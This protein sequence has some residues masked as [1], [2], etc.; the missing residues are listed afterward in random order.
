MEKV[1]MIAGGGTGGHIYPA[2]ALGQEIKRLLPQGRIIYIGSKR[3]LEVKLMEQ[4]Q[5][6]FYGLNVAGLKGK[7]LKVINNLLKLPWSLGQAWRL[8]HQFRP[9]LVIGMGGYS[10]GPV[11]LAASWKKIPS[12]LLEQNARLGMTNKLLL[13]R[14]QK[15]IVSFP[16]T[17]SACGEKG[18]YIGNPVRPE[19][20]QVPTQRKTKEKIF[21]LFVFGGSQGSHFLNQVV[22]QSLPFLKSIKEQLFIIHQTGEKEYEEIKSAYDQIG[23]SSVLI[24][25]FFDDM[26]SILARTDLVVC[27]A[28]ATTI[29][30]LIAAQQPALLVPFA[31]A[32]DNHQYYNALELV[33]AEAALMATEEEFSSEFLVDK[34]NHFLQHREELQKYRANLALLRNDQVT[35]KIAHLCLSYLD[36]ENKE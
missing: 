25:P 26:A 12:L 19:F 15:I 30:E 9:R 8:L 14:A 31:H 18:K 35:E 6:E 34:I 1:I 36:G 16:S 2:L 3:P 23:F 7:G 24:E 5:V 28:G 4:H 13:K 27:R 11:V 22:L 33:K 20:Y 29:A 32:S 10:S 21:T 17:L